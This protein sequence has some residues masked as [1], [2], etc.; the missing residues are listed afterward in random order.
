MALELLFLSQEDIINLGIFDYKKNLEDVKKAILWHQD[1]LSLSKKIAIDLDPSLE[2]KI[3]SLVGINANYSANKWLGSNIN[4]KNK[5]LPRAVSIIVLNDKTTGIP[6]ALMD[7][8]LISAVRTG[9]Y[10]SLIMKYLI[11]NKSTLGIIGSGVMART[12]LMSIIETQSELIDNILVYSKHNAS[13]FVNY[14]KSRYP[15]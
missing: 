8:T 1:F 10:A 13:N 15:N 11:T 3:N 4:N 2:W 14:F 6:L 7:G 5:D 12:S 9:S